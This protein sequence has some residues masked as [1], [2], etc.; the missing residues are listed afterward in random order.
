[1]GILILEIEYKVKELIQMKCSV[2][3]CDL[4]SYIY[5]QHHDGWGFT[6]YKTEYLQRYQCINHD[7][8]MYKL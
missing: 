7:C 3:G 8:R 6:N 4:K 2:C 5:E 1:M